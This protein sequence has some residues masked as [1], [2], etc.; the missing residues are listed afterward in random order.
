M[1]N[2]VI[3]TSV[4]FSVL[5][6]SAAQAKTESYK[7]DES[8]TSVVMSWSHL[9][10]SNPTAS[11]HHVEGIVKFDPKTKIVS[12]VDISIPTASIDTGVP[13]LNKEFSQSDYFDTEKYPVASFK[14]TRITMNGNDYEVQGDLT[15]KSITRPVT[16]H[17][18]LNKSGF[19]EM[20]KKNAVGFNV[21]GVIK[22]A[23]FKIDKY[24]PYVSNE[25]KLTISSEAY[26]DN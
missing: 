8:H 24:V 4:L 23:D 1:K 15:I 14:S 16:L 3:T 2:S 20:E 26:S 19:Q 7:L 5:I 10:F 18:T 12:L 11:I 13:A 22:R 21:S 17:A 25:I 6:A 9:G